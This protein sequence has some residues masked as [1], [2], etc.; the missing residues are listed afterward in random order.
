MEKKILNPIETNL[1]SS[2]N[3]QPAAGIS[4]GFGPM[5]S[6]S[7]EAV[8][9]FSQN[10]NKKLML[11]ASKNQIDYNRGYVNN[12]NTAE[13][14]KFTKSL[15]HRY[16]NAQVM[17]CRDH[18]GPGF[19]GNNDLVDSYKTIETDID[20]G[21]DMMHIDFCH[22]KS[23]EKLIL[24]KQAIEFCK[25]LSPAIELEIG[26][27]ENLGS[28]YDEQY[29]KTIKEEI[30]YFLDFCKP[31]YYVVQTGSLVMKYL[32]A[33]QFNKPFVTQ[34][35]QLL[36][37]K[38]I[39]IKEH[40]S[41]YF[42]SH[43]IKNRLGIINAMNIAPQLGVVQTSTVINASL[44]YGVDIQEFVNKCYA[45]GKWKKW[46]NLE[47]NVSPLEATIV[48]GHYHFASDAYK[49]IVDSLNQFAD[50]KE[51][52]I[53]KLLDIIRHYDKNSRSLS[54]STKEAILV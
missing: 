39:E 43:D 44:I 17:L 2:E 32:Q 4:F 24:M 53:E 22:H 51:I 23:E 41:D 21:F 11:I 46:F 14:V 52:I 9:R 6:E 30:D 42:T 37:S 18:C 19:N 7:I 54:I 45:A 25:K 29:L 27:D 8:F 12:W 47:L 50:I 1:Q 35:V 48:A 34:V 40:N 31:K 38:N 15:M 13:Y 28:L 33:G 16:P 10:F 36:N 20:C 3:Y 26:T 49:R 5:S